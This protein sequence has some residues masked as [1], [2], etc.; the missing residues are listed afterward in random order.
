MKKSLL[1]LGGLILTSC[2]ATVPA[3]I[4]L[5][6]NEI[7]RGSASGSLG[8]NA[9]ITVKN[10]DGL[11]CEGKMFVPSSAANTEG[12]IECNDKRKGHFIANGKAKSW[13]GEGKLDDG[14]TFSIL[15]GPQITTIKY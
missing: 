6:S 4:K 12:T 7:L 5:Q 13:A 10:I 14:S 2:S 9:E 11:S 8:S 15:I 3:T 1:I